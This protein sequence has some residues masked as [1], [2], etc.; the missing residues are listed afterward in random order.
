MLNRAAFL[1]GDHELVADELKA[2]RQ[3][4][5]PRVMKVI[6]ETS[7]LESPAAIRTASKLAMHAGADWIKTSTGKAKT[8][9]TPVAVL[10]MAEAIAEHSAQ[11][12]TPVGL[13]ISGG[14]RTSADALGYLAIIEATL[15][16]AWLQPDR[17]RF[18]ASGLLTAL[19]ADLAAMRC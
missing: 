12:A 4:V 3:Q 5:G 2:M 18:G 15:G 1:A 13:K 8:G 19:V 10:A 11:R 7:E 9:A 16:P 14:V 17:V 6:L